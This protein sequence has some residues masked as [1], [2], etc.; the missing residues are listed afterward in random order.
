MTD[1][2]GALGSSAHGILSR[3][4]GSEISNFLF[5]VYTFIFVPI[6]LL[7]SVIKWWPIFYKTYA[8]ISSESEHSIKYEMDYEIVCVTYF[9]YVWFW[10]IISQ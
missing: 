10:E 1:L 7:D 3:W 8:N 4:S 6:N 9:K 2:F 5:I